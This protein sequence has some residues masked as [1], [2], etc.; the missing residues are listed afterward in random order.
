MCGGSFAQ[1]TGATF[2]TIISLGGTPSDIIL[3][4]SR[5]RL[6]LVSKSKNDVEVVDCQNNQ[7]IRSIP[8]GNTPLAAAMSVDNLH[9]YV[10]NNA[11]SSLSVINLNSL[12]VEQTLSLSAA[13]EG[14]AVGADGRVLISTEGSGTSDSINSLLLYDSSLASGQQ[15]TAISFPPPATTPTGL[16]VSTT[17]SATTFT[18]KLIRTPDGAFIIGMSN[19]NSN[20]FTVLFVYETASATVLRS[21]KVTGQ[22]TV[23]SIAPDGSHFM[24]GY[25]LYDTATLAA[26]AQQNVSNIPFPLS[27][28]GTATFNTRQNVGGSVFSP[29]GET[30]FSA[31]NV[32]PFSTP[33]T[34]VQATALRRP[35][36]GV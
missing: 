20:A 27:S 26:L 16:S 2:G 24:A 34:R 35:R 19:V 29:D 21:R 8:V 9:L 23:L 17:T 30:L 32:A 1:S 12:S 10:T 31:F 3:D 7:V 6:Y 5:A 18:G 22:S 4:E 33:A 11:D 36:G 13:P 25:T 14:V 28:T 15:V